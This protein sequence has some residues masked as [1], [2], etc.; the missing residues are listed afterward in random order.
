MIY[1]WIYPEVDYS[2]YKLTSDPEVNLHMLTIRKV[3]TTIVNTFGLIYPQNHRI[4]TEV[5]LICEVN[6]DI[7]T[8]GKKGSTKKSE[9][10]KIVQFRTKIKENVTML[11]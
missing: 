8:I 9:L 6:L 2:R 7:L 10:T 4:Y 11:A 1:L 3:L 5:R